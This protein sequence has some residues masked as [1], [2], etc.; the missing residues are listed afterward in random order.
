MKLHHLGHCTSTKNH[1]LSSK[2]PKPT[3][4]NLSSCW[5]EECK[6]LPKQDRVFLV[7]KS[8]LL[9]TPHPQRARAS[10]LQTS[11]HSTGGQGGSNQQSHP[12]VM[13]NS[14][15][16][17]GQQ[18]H[19]YLGSN[20]CC[21]TELKEGLLNR[22]EIMLASVNLVSYSMANEILGL[23]KP[24]TISSLNQCSSQLQSKYLPLY[25]QVNTDLTSHQRSFFLQQQQQQQQIII[26]RH[27]LP[28]A[29][30]ILYN[31]RPTDVGV[32][33]Y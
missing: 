8:I 16:H 1:R 32:I 22:R 29:Q 7:S 28:K 4:R 15:Q 27:D 6:R 31:T 17:M 13:P 11:C 20:Q 3:M 26:E 12:A 23:R 25:P 9:K 19:S 21:L 33:S 2:T 18:W 24:T 10:F 30:V 5:S 14:D